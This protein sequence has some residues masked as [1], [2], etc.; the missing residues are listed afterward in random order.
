MRHIMK[1]AKC[2]KY[3]MKENCCSSATIH[4][5][6]PKFSPEDQYA[7]YRRKAKAGLYKQKGL[8]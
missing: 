7:D 2:G 8:I 3:T 1:C 4:A 5:A 6:P